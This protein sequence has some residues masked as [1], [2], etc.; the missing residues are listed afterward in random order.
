MSSNFKYTAGLNNVGSYQVSAIPY[1]TASATLAGAA[2]AVKIVFP[3]VT[4]WIQVRNTDGSKTLLMALSEEQCAA[5]GK[6]NLSIKNGTSTDVYNW[7]ITELYLTG[8]DTGC[9]F[10]IAAGLTN[11]PIERVDNIAPS[12]SNWSGSVG[13]G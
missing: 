2:G 6:N 5:S 12:G 4:S 8:S 13:V 1:L 7:K 11:L 3:Y 9:L 10:E